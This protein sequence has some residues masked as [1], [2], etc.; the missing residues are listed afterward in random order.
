MIYVTYINK[1]VRNNSS[2][3]DERLRGCHIMQLIKIKIV[4]IENIIYLYY[5]II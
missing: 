5:I 3:Y 2:Y 1:F 4:I